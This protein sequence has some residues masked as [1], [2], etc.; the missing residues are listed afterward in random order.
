MKITKLDLRDSRKTRQ[1]RNYQISSDAILTKTYTQIT[2][3]DCN[4]EALNRLLIDLGLSYEE[5]QTRC[6]SDSIFCQVVAR[7]IAIN[8]TR[9]GKI[10]EKFVIEVVAESVSD[11]GFEITTKGAS[12]T[13]FT[14]DGRILTTKEMTK[15][16][17]DHRKETLKAADFLIKGKMNGYGF[18]KIVFS[19]GDDKEFEGGHQ[20][21][22]LKEIVHFLEWAKNYGS[23][24][25]VFIT[26][27]DGDPIDSLKKYQSDNIWVVNHVE[28]QEKLQSL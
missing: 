15:L 2:K 21:N 25:E 27:I 4:I 18:A 17:L 22:V 10:D 6:V 7:Y 19:H 9:Q 23:K 1:N 14:N 28:L 26:L 3:S 16:G 8:A 11:K 5:L 12:E 20:S 13:R 24:D